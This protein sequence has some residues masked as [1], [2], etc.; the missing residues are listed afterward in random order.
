MWK[1]CRGKI[2]KSINPAT[3]EVVFNVSSATRRDVILA[4][5][6]A[7]KGLDYWKE[8]EVK[9]RIH[10]VKKFSRILWKARDELAT[11]VTIEMGKPIRESRGEIYVCK[12]EIEVLCRQFR[13]VYKRGT[14]LDNKKIKVVIFNEAKGI[15]GIITP[16]NFPLI[17]PISKIVQSLLVGNTVVF[18]PSEVVP[19]TSIKLT[20]VIEDT[21]LPSGVVNTIIGDRSVG[22][23]LIRSPIDVISFT[24]V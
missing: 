14:Y 12:K 4:I 3:E 9:E 21:G 11:L 2:I 19:V 7:K 22:K 20:E 13:K 6:A 18:K 17:I 23:I 16:W 24:V 8:V 15:S 5:Q 1:S 10:I